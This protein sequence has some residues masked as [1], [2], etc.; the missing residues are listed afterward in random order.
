[1]NNQKNVWRFIIFILAV[2]STSPL[3]A[4]QK[5]VEATM[6]LAALFH[7]STSLES[8]IKGN[9]SSGGKIEVTVRDKNTNTIVFQVAITS[10]STEFSGT[11]TNYNKSALGS[12]ATYYPNVWNSKDIKTALGSI[13]RKRYDSSTARPYPIFSNNID[14][15]IQITETNATMNVC[16][17]PGIGLVNRDGGNALFDSRHYCYNLKNASSL[18]TIVWTRMKQ[19][20]ISKPIDLSIAAH[21]GIW[22]DN[23]GTGSPENSIEAIRRTKQFTDI[24]E[25]DIM[26]TKDKQLVVS[27][28]YNMDRLSD[29]SGSERD[30]LFN[31]NGS[32]LDNLHLRRRNMQVSGFKYLKF[33]DLVDAL[34]ANDLV[35]TIDI[36]DII[37]RTKNGVC[38]DNCEYD[39]K[40]HGEEARRKTKESWM[41][42]FKGCIRIAASKH[43]LQ[44]IAF[45]VPH[46]YDDLKNYMSEDTLS[47]VLFMPVIQPGRADY[48][49]FTDSWIS[50]GNERVIAYETNFKPSTDQALKP[51]TRG[52][53][54]Y[55]NFL[56]YVYA[57]TGLRPGCYPE[58]PMG[59]KGIVSRWA[60]WK[61][62]DLTQ[63]IRGDHYLLM[64]IPYGKIMVLTTDRPDIWRRISEI[65]NNIPH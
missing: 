12:G 8:G 39:P 41:D 61:I 45:K 49:D 44:Y 23:L 62:K 53:K 4:F 34:V 38:I 63:D 5:E 20:D 58:E 56:H 11:G 3:Y 2:L 65:Y 48:L 14:L 17:I 6:S 60:D 19:P 43:A 31:L 22:G 10:T 15:K 51:I 64:T 50:H 36:K 21:R 16:K 29:Y 26:I 24:L 33:G 37:A 28:D 1:M 32:V 55:E 35:L 18:P 25:S 46:T 9:V 59:P 47:Q 27:H 30:Y 7:P 54:T 42:I 13:D 40:T 57:R 52:G